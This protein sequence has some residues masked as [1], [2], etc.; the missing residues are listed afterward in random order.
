[1]ISREKK[2]ARPATRSATAGKWCLVV[3]ASLLS[4]LLPMA[5]FATAQDFSQD[6]APM[7]VA[8]APIPLVRF[9]DVSATSF[10]PSFS[11]TSGYPIGDGMAGAAWFDFDR[12]GL[13]DLFLTGG[14]GQNNALY[15]NNGNGTFTD[16]AAAT[17][18]Q[19]GLGNAAVVP[20]DLDNDGDQDLFLTG[21]GGL[22]GAGDTPFRLYRNDFVATGLPV[23]FT[24]VTANSGIGGLASHF[25]AALGDIDNDGLLD[26][27]VTA[28]GSF[29]S[30]GPTARCTPGNHP[31]QLFHNLGGL[32]FGNISDGSNVDTSF[33]G[34]TAFFGHLD[35]DPFIDLFVGNCNGLVQQ[36]PPMPWP[37]RPV[38]APNELFHNNGG[39]GLAF[40]D[41]GPTSGFGQLGFYMG[42]A[43]ADFNND[44]LVD[45][46]A[47]NVG[48]QNGMP[49]G[50][51]HAFFLKQGPLVGPP[52]PNYVDLTV[53]LGMNTLEF[54]WGATAQDWDNDGFTDLYYAGA[55]PTFGIQSNPGRMFLNQLPAPGGFLDVTSTLPTSANLS[56]R[57]SS[58]VASADY[59]NDGDMDLVV[60]TDSFGGTS[61]A[62][63]LL[64]NQ[65]RQQLN[66][67]GSLTV[68]LQGDPTT[69]TNRDG[70]GARIAVEA[71]IGGTAQLQFKEVYAGSGLLSHNSQWQVF[72]LG[73]ATT[74]TRLAVW[75]PNNVIEFFPNVGPNQQVR[76]VQ[77]TGAIQ[78]GC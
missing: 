72:G 25:D 71:V 17:G 56:N 37:V 38:Q 8:P 54:G 10:S 2:K 51:P 12:D 32:T 44:L 36:F 16:V 29:C 70:V 18:V 76:L 40:T 14:V 41:V 35:N 22:S 77:G 55:L 30:M 24:D 21:D 5:D 28:S 11:H 33:G 64:R 73:N 39:T 26:L 6:Q 68:C 45:I 49:A 3:S 74:T 61:G 63:L 75:W 9:Q 57:F 67:P 43:P 4:S 15:K 27:F 20:A 31:N 50:S 13:L 69:G 42:F 53:A 48:S 59:D 23:T 62:P 1:M 34:C 58:G 7:V 60:A 66:P 46:F 19:N 65:I 47:T 52:N 78:P